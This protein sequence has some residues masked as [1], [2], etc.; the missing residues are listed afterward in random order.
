MICFFVVVSALCDSQH[1]QELGNWESSLAIFETIVNSAHGDLESLVPKS[2]NRDINSQNVTCLQLL[3]A[4]RNA[5]ASSAW[6][7]VEVRLRLRV[8]ELNNR[9]HAN[10]F[11]LR[12]F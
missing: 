2:W 7:D 3:L 9:I 6:S 5:L 11:A 1:D 8:N 10:D 4:I 12:S